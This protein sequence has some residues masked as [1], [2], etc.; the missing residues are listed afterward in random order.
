M[1]QTVGFDPGEELPPP[2]IMNGLS[3]MTILNQ[4]ADLEVF[5]SYQ[6]ARCDERV[7]LL[8]GEIFALPLDLQ[9]RFGQLFAGLGAILA[10]FLLAGEA[11]LQLLELLLCLAKV[12]GVLHRV[13]IRIG[14]IGL[15]SHI[16]AELLPGG[17]MGNTALAL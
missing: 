8:A 5:E 7:R 11:A 4:V 10:P 14:G 2:S 6:I 16:D 3:Q 1:H 17:N 9:M 13:A 15:E 12:A